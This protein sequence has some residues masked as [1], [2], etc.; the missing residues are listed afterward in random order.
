MSEELQQAQQVAL[1]RRQRIINGAKGFGWG[2]AK[3]MMPH[4][5]YKIAKKGKKRVKHLHNKYTTA[6]RLYLEAQQQGL[7]PN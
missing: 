4:G 2:A 6:R 7:I 5:L 3:F 1:T